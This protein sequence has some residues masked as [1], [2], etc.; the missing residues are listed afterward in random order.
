VTGVVS[1]AGG[2]QPGI[3]LTQ[4]GIFQG[5]TKVALGGKVKVKVVG[6]VQPG[7]LLTSS[8]TPGCA[9]AVKNRRKAFGA[10]IGKALAAPDAEGLV[11]MLVMMR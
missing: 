6:K 11:L 4:E 5:N 8:S 3:G 2:I 7:D 10:V 1:G 9:M